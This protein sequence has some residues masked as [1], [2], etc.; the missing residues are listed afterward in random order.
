MTGGRAG[1]ARAMAAFSSPACRS[2]SI[3][4]VAS[5]VFVLAAAPAGSEGPPAIP[6][7]D[8]FG[9]GLTLQQVTP[10]SVVAARPDE[11]TARPVL[12]H[13]RLSEVCQRKGCWTMLQDGDQTVRVRFKDYGF[14][15]PTE[16]SGREAYVEGTVKVSVLSEAEARHYAEES[17]SGDPDAIHGP[18][19]EIGFTATG[20]RLLRR[21]R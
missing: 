19:R 20:V 13:G 3:G 4:F 16:A 7:G 17:P 10:L 9:A 1:Y 6:S 8:D 12:L 14:F 21:S 5:M 18:Q 11:W 2:V 15:I